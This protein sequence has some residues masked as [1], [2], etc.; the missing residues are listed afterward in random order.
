M[1]HTLVESVRVCRTCKFSPW[2]R[3]KRLSPTCQRFGK[4]GNM[5]LHSRSCW[6]GNTPYSD[7]YR[8]RNES[9]MEEDFERERENMPNW[10]RRGKP[11]SKAT[12]QVTAPERGEATDSVD[13]KALRPYTYLRCSFYS[14]CIS[15][16]HNFSL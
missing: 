15:H 9:R 11:K 4:S 12:Q 13:G 5:P 6:S 14:K 1:M 3:I 8:S 7:E 2:I 10:H 16:F